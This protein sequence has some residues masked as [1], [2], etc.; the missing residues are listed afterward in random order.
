[1]KKTIDEFHK[2][3][4]ELALNNVKLNLNDYYELFNK[5]AETKKEDK[6]K[7]ELKKVQSA[8]RKQIVKSFSN[9]DAKEIFLLLDKKELIKDVLEPWTKDKGV[10]FDEEFKTF[11][12]YFTG[13][14]QNRKNMYSD[15]EKS[16]AIAFRLIHE[17]FPKFL[18]NLKA[19]EKINQIE[20]LK[21]KLDKIY[22]DF[23]QYL[24]INSLDELFTLDY[25]NE[26]LTQKGIEVYNN[27]I[28]GRTETEGKLKIQ[29]INEIINLYNQ[30]KDKKDKLPKL[31]Q[32][33]KQILS[34]RISLSFLPESFEKSIDIFEAIH[35]FYSIN[36]LS[37]K[38]ENA[39]Q[40]ENL[41]VL[42]KNILEYLPT[43]DLSKIYLKNDTSLTTISQKI[44]G[45]FG[46][47]QSAL[48]YR[49]EAEINPKYEADYKK[50]NEKKR[51][52][53]E[54]E[55]AKY[56]KQEYFTI[57][58][59]QETLDLYVQSLEKD[60]EI[61]QKHSSNNIANYFKHYFVAKKENET[62]KTFDFI[63]NITA[64]YQCIQ[65]ILENREQ[66]EDELKQDQKL[67][68]NIKF[69]LDAVL[70]VL[71]F[72][73]PLHLKSENITEK[74]TLFY[75]V[76]ELYYE[77]LSLLTPLYNMVRNYVTQK[78]YSTKKIKLNFE[79]SSFLSGWSQDYTTKG[80]LIIKKDNNYY[81]LIVE[82]KLSEVDK[83]RL[84]QN[85]ELNLAYRIVM[86]FQKPDN[87]NTPR[88]FI[89]SK[90]T[91]YAPAVEKYNLP[92]N[93]VIE[94]YDNGKFK[95][96]YRKKNKEDYKVSLIKMIDYFKEGFTKHDSYK[97]YNFSWKPS[98]EY[99][100]ISQFYNDVENS[101]YQLY[102][103]MINFDTLL[104]MVSEGKLYLFQIYNK[105]FSP[106]SKGK[107]NMHT[108]YWKAL[109]EEQNLKNIFYA[110][111]GQAEIFFREKSIKEKN[112]ITHP[113]H[114][115]IK[116]KNPLTPDAENTFVYDLVKDKRYTVDKFQFHV[117]IT[118][119]FKAKGNNYINQEVLTYLKNNPEV[120]IIGL[121]RGERHLVYLTLI[122]QKGN[123]L[124]Q[125][126]LNVIKDE[127]NET[128]YHTLLHNKET[129]REK[130]RQNWRSIENIKELKEGYISQ[131]VHK[132]TKMMVE[133]N[134][135]VVMEDLNF[136][137]KRGRFKV[138]KQIYQKLEKML[139]DKLNYLVL[140]DKQ[141]TEL[142]GLYNALQLANKFESFQKMGKQSGF[143]F[144]V[145][146]WNTSKIDPT[147]GFVNY[148]YT[149]YE[150]VEKAQKFFNTFET[151]RFNKEKNYFE[152]MVKN[153]SDFNSKA[154]DTQ[155]EWT[156][157][158]HGERIETKR[159][160][161]Q[162]NNFISETINLTQK[163]EVF[164]GKNNITYG[165]G[166][167]LI[168]QITAKTEKS[169]FEELLYLFKLTLQMRN[170]VT[171]TE[172]DYLISPVMNAKGT[173]YDSR[174]YEK[175]EN[176]TLPKDA[177]ANGAY[178]IARKGIILL[179]KIN[180][181]DLSKKVDL[182]QTNREWLQFAQKK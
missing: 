26:V 137:F 64:K 31:K 4:I 28:G 19:F 43:Y 81:L 7:E 56:T 65:G 135:I 157:C 175:L 46:I 85:P 122:D 169:F 50:A 153:Y 89:R 125:E 16:T 115:P 176:P 54:K 38:T 178:N 25:F 119:N 30:N 47:F 116:A 174:D 82:K 163:F 3:F 5:S 10:Y 42:I 90:G 132:I 35:Q 27:I 124:H 114:Q 2:Y 80:G 79:N 106:Y 6:Y 155:Q 45:D 32:L 40:T 48:N 101:C 173:F 17:N 148:F 104:E 15:E 74:D 136:G 44:F 13:F 53:L 109:F 67:I 96:E 41:L 166:A 77:E 91:N 126:S 180:K 121:D 9:G 95:T 87:K 151:I 181:A 49:Y 59:L 92:I 117:P 107:Q 141:P 29:G 1:M 66:Y 110:L 76:F 140:K 97:H 86:D 147:T 37:Y 11:T 33:Y 93:D 131:V 68:D 18:E 51:E 139:I 24:N 112:I 118:L 162:N 145:P 167:N 170:S 8:L 22:K 154:D 152:F 156:I 94:I 52:N 130:A 129:E 62:D 88:L 99:D 177:D 39:E 57:S 168:S 171:G 159:Q 69:F 149:K 161:D 133:Y 55:K 23:E 172:E 105:D 71:H 60:H 98:N 108:M 14:N 120:N 142:G 102:E 73:K 20:S 72:I 84:K 144:Y 83:N 75:D 158:T 164:F 128:P 127:K 113:A 143:I 103:E 134:A 12:T 36:L 34:D 61:S 182:F 165:D 146:A 58:Y 123:I 179:D 70:E 160:K 100:D 63:S 138:E 78:P 150:N 111:N 21:P